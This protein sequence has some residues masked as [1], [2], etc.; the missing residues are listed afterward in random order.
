MLYTVFQCTYRQSENWWKQRT[1]IVTRQF[2][3][4]IL[5]N[6]H[7]LNTSSTNEYAHTQSTFAPV[8]ILL[9][10]YIGVLIPPINNVR[11]P[12]SFGFEAPTRMS[13]EAME[14]I[15]MP[16]QLGKGRRKVFNFNV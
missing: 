5:E 3:Q 14:R 11:I 4:W 2:A 16:L 1:L 8:D 7:Q 10:K 12:Y 13:Q 15:I 6:A 9:Q